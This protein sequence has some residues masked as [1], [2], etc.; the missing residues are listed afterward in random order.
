MIRSA[1]FS[2]VT[3]ASV[4]ALGAG[5]ASTPTLAPTPDTKLADGGPGA[6]SVAGDVRVIAT[7]DEWRYEP[8]ELGEFVTPVH[9]TIRND[10]DHP[11]RV[12]FS[13]IRMMGDNGVRLS[14]LPPYRVEI[15][16]AHV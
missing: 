6:T 15:G 7:L 2:L 8:K 14:A 9:V 3:L 11:I 10:S 13:D 5:C 12:R 16:R 4:L 1:L